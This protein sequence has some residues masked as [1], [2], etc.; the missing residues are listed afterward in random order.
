MLASY[1]CI[2]LL[3]YVGTIKVS[4]EMEIAGIT[5]TQ[6]TTCTGIHNY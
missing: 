5:A 1:V 4:D 3:Y 6:K 2:T